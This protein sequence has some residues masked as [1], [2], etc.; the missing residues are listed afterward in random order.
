MISLSKLKNLYLGSCIKLERLP[1]LGKL[2]LLESLRIHELIKLKLGA[3]FLGIKSRNK[4]K[5][6]DIIIFPKLKYL[7]IRGLQEW[8][9]WIEIG[10][11]RQE[12]EEDDY[13]FTIMP[14]IHFLQICKCPKLK[15]LPNFLRTTLQEK[16]LLTRLK[17]PR[18]IQISKVISEG[19]RPSKAIVFSLV[20]KRDFATIPSQI[21]NL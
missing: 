5:K 10:G 16:S 15:S 8:E 18:K 9:E 7:E 3:E 20:V 12:G 13:C 14:R 11:M 4:N 2:P 17:H 19:I 21:N 1:L 6:D